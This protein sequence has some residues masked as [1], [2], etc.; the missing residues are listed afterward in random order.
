MW[1]G[2]CRLGFVSLSFLGVINVDLLLPTIPGGSFPSPRQRSLPESPG[3]VCT[4]CAG[5][6][7]DAGAVQPGLSKYL[8]AAHSARWG[9]E[10]SLSSGPRVPRDREITHSQCVDCKMGSQEG[11]ATIVNGRD[12]G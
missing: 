7:A 2:K 8:R 4:V 6:L 12:G 11:G 10:S 5:P 3:G 9:S 1:L